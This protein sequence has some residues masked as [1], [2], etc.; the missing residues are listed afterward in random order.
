MPLVGLTPAGA[1]E[2]ES[3][4]AV[5]V[6]PG[7]AHIAHGYHGIGGLAP[8]IAV[9]AVGRD[10]VGV[11]DLAHRTDAI[12]HKE[13]LVREAWGTVLAPQQ[14]TIWPIGKRGVAEGSGSECGASCCTCR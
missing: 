13:V 10:R 12:G 5:G 8:R 2:H 3:E 14:P 4:V 6:F 9:L 1:Q 7:K 11:E